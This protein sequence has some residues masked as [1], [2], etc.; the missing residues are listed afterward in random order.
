M[1]AALAPFRF[2]GSLQTGRLLEEDMH[3]GV[4]ALVLEGK[5]NL[6]LV[7]CGSLLG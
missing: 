1:S 4:N 5:H 6:Q 2:P 3:D 7:D